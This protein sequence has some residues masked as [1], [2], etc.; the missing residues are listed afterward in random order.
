MENITFKIYNSVTDLPQNWDKV[1][2]YNHF[3]QKPYL[4]VLEKSAPTNMECFFIGIFEKE[5]LIGTALAQYLD[6]NKLESFGERDNCFK[7]KIRNFVFRNFASHV[8]FIGNNMI[9]GQNGYTFIKPIDFKYVSNVMM[10]CSTA[11]IQHFKEK[12]ITIHIVSFKDFYTE[13]SV[14]LKKYDFGSLYEFSAQPN[15]IFYLNKNWKTKEDYIQTFS[16]KYRDQYKRAHKKIEGIDVRELSYD[17]VV[18]YEPNI[19][20]LY[21]YVAKNAPFNTFFLDKHH[22]STFKKQCGNRFRICGYFLNEKLVGFHTILLNGETLETYFLGYDETIQKE[23]MLY[24]NMLYNMTEFGIENGF[25]KI[26][27]GRTA[28]EIK[29]SI[30]AEPVN[31]SGFILH[32]NKWVNKLMDKIF[33]KLEPEVHWQPRHPFK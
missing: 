17:D 20:N 12:K 29:S 9:T 5:E 22:F 27:F 2:H 6:L 28:L 7:T 13:C 1:S 30:G 3:L 23:S 8:L 24:L 4:S 32:T 11:L 33:P 18:K 10:Q 16:K 31:M 21:Y 14:E 25:K 15:M 26:I 19:Y